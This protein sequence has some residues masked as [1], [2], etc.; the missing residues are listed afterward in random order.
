L[1]PLGWAVVH[2]ALYAWRL[3]VTYQHGRYVMPVLPVIVLYGVM[4]MLRLARPAHNRRLPRLVSLSWLASFALTMPVFLLA[5]GAP[6]YARD[7]RVIETEMVATSHWLAD[8]TDADTLIAVHDIGAV[9]YFAGRPLVDLAGL[10]SPD[11]IPIIRD[12]G[13][14]LALMEHRGADYLV[15]FPN[16]YQNIVA[17]PRVCL[18]YATNGRWA[19]DAG[20][21]ENMAVYALHWGGE[22]CP[23]E[24]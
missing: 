4:G 17:D 8:N 1:L 12:E 11:V 10:V 13:A 6:A 7:V 15:T 14:L 3:P 16:W 5:L 23:T 19:P 24:P 18:V 9:G 22:S 20:V 2:I 21:E